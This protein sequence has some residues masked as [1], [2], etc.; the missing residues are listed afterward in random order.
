MVGLYVASIII[1][2]VGPIA[3]EKITWKFF[4]VLIIP[5]ALHF[6]NVYFIFPETKQR[7]LE[8][9]NQAFGER[10]AV[11]YYGATAEDEK[12]YEQAM[13]EDRVAHGE[14]EKAGVGE[15]GV[16]HVEKV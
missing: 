6:C 4:I 12:V 1:L 5:T 3:L 15:T 9:I 2:S 13:R 14:V 7:S 16:V 10:V 11:H 8:D